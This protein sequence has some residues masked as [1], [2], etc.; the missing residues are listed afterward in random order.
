MN[1]FAGRVSVLA[2]GVLLIAE[3]GCA[4]DDL[5]LPDPL[6]TRAGNKIATPAQWQEVRR[7]EILELF[8]DLNERDSVTVVIVTHESRVADI[9]D[10]TL[11]LSGGA[12]V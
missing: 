7:P 12:L 4:A 3:T 8:R 1:A 9:A 5:S 6:T 10:L 2:A 11:E